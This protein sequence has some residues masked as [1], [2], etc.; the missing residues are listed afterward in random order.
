MIYRSWNKMLEFSF[1]YNFFFKLRR[2]PKVVTKSYFKTHFPTVG[3]ADRP[4]NDHITRKINKQNQFRPEL[5]DLEKQHKWTHVQHVNSNLSLLSLGLWSIYMQSLYAWLENDE[6]PW[7]LS[8]GCLFKWPFIFTDQILG[9]RT[10]YDSWQPEVRQYVST[11][12]S[13]YTEFIK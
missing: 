1:A 3:H 13:Q 5:E 7:A 12:Y 9:R 10:G 2:K 11:D 4:K 8:P 6:L